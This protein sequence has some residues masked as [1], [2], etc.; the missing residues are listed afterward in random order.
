[1]LSIKIYIP[2]FIFEY[3]SSLDFT[4]INW[5]GV[6][7]PLGIFKTIREWFH[8]EQSEQNLENIGM[9][10]GSTF[11]N[12]AFLF[13]ILALGTFM[14][15]MLKFLIVM[16]RYIIGEGKLVNII[17][18]INK[19]FRSGFYSCIIFEGVIIL[20]LSSLSEIKRLFNHGAEGKE[21]SII[22]AIGIITGL[23]SFLI[24]IIVIRKS[25]RFGKFGE[26]ELFSEL[27]DGGLHRL[28]PALFM[29]RRLLL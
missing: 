22:F 16:V 15:L 5:E 14:H 9:E 17:S 18:V 4:L 10:S 24:F 28:Y 2:S 27:R 26:R 7:K 21:L 12:N 8:Y 25:S 3:L 19:P 20:G 23:T 13:F 1:M 29:G 6:W 11:V